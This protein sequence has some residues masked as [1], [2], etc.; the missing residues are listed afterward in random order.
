MATFLAI[1]SVLSGTAS[2]LGLIHIL[3]GE[4]Q[5]EFKKITIGA[6][7][8]T[9]ILSLYILFIPGTYF[10]NS[11]NSKI[12]RYSKE[13][14][15]SILIQQGDFSFGG[16]KSYAVKFPEPFNKAP[17]VEIINENGY[18]YAPYVEKTTQFQVVFKRSSDDPSWIIPQSFQNYIWIAKGEPLS[19]YSAANPNN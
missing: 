11:V 10:E 17:K 1:F 8:I 18:N 9:G 3:K 14:T 19:Q 4:A 7:I 2:I 13:A 16:M 6:F 15:N 5:I 12:Q